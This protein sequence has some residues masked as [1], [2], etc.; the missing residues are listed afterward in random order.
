MRLH[1]DDSLVTDSQNVWSCCYSLSDAINQPII[2]CAVLD[3][4]RRGN[5]SFVDQERDPN[6]SIK[7]IHFPFHDSTSLFF[8]VCVRL[9][10]PLYC[11]LQ[12]KVQRY[13][14]SSMWEVEHKLP[15]RHAHPFHPHSLRCVLSVSQEMRGPLPTTHHHSLSFHALF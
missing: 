2:Q 11:Y 9:C 5:R 12:S 1:G 14:S 6:F 3:N 15:G 7:D 8:I 10:F 13:S 4:S